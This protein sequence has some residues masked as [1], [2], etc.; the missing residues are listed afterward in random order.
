MKG[1]ND[2][3]EEFIES[4]ILCYFMGKWCNV[5]YKNDIKGYF[6]QKLWVYRKNKSNFIRNWISDITVLRKWKYIAIEVKKISE[7]KFFDRDVET[8]RQ[9]LWIA[10]MKWLSKSRINTYVHAVEQREFLDDVIKE[11]WVWFFA[12][13]LEQVKE[14]LEENW[15]LELFENRKKVD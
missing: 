2:K 3:K 5:F 4:E 6:D 8:L 13:S 9:N 7:M 12:S 11:W 14:R 1:I 15:V 10:Q